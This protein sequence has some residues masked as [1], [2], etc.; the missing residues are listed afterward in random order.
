MSKRLTDVEIDELVE[1][2]LILVTMKIR[3]GKLIYDLFPGWR[4]SS[5]I[6]DL[7]P[8]DRDV[9]EYRLGL[10][11][12]DRAKEALLPEGEIRRG[13]FVYSEKSRD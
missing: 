9:F 10:V 12:I 5:D 8:D 13:D 3:E 4:V 1:V 6:D 2:V 7:H 11:W